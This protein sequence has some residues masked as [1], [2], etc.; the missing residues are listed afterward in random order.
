MV[1][2]LATAGEKRISWATRSIPRPSKAR[3]STGP[4]STRC[5]AISRPASMRARCVTGGERFGS[6]GY[7]IKPTIFADVKDNMK[8]ATEEIFGPVMQVLKFKDVEEVVSVPMPPTTASA[9]VWT[10]DIKKAHTIAERLRAGRGLDQ[11]LRR[12]RRGRPFGGFKS[13]GIGRE[14][15][16]GPRQL[17]GAQD[18]DC[19]NGLAGL[20]SIATIDEP[21]PPPRRRGGDDEPCVPARPSCRY[22]T[23]QTLSTL[24]HMSSAA[25]RA[26]RPAWFR[27]V[28]RHVPS[29]AGPAAS[30]G[31]LITLRLRILG[32]CH[33]VLPG[34]YRRMLS[35]FTTPIASPP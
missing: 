2:R 33:P 13:S 8:I 14:L 19:C 21:S 9:A 28:A 29:H 35:R 31:S 5:S 23:P 27:R 1:E 6:K 11:L 18:R 32:F 34:P 20:F 15:G 26:D 25:W 24:T 4:S 3:R 22:T 12:I 10:R 17:Y 7:F 16:E 30:G